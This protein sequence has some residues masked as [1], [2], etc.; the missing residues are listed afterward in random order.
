MNLM[1]GGLTATTTAI[2]QLQVAMHYLLDKPDYSEALGLVGSFDLDAVLLGDLAQPVT[3]FLPNNEAVTSPESRPLLDK[4]FAENK[5]NDVTLYH[6]VAGYFDLDAILATK[7]TSVTT[8][9]GLP[10]ALSYSADG[11]FVG[12]DMHMRVVDPN[13]YNMTGQVV[14]HGIDHVLFPPDF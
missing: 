3:V 1:C 6:V 11:V 12:A 9:S 8:L 5:V 2:G 7:P 10:L 4:S 13:L 14:I